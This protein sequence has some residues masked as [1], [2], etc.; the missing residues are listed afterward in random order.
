VRSDRCHYNKVVE[1]LVLLLMMG[2][3]GVDAHALTALFIE[4]LN[5]RDI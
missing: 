1:N 3:G 2:G 5:S 4:G